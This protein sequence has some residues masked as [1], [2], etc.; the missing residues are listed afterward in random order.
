MYFLSIKLILVERTKVAKSDCPSRGIRSFSR[1]LVGEKRQ[2]HLFLRDQ[3]ACIR[4]IGAS[5][6]PEL[7]AQ[8]LEMISAGELEHIIL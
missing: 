8:A 7:L 3:I 6:L 1:L 4:R 5:H 2:H